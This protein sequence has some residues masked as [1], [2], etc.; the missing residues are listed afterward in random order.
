MGRHHAEEFVE[1][2]CRQWAVIKRQLLGVD[3]PKLAKE[4]IGALRSTL[5]QRRDLHAGSTS[6][7]RVEQ[8]WPEVFEGDAA[9]VNQVYR[10]MNPH[11]KTVLELHYI[12]RVPTYQKA[13]ALAMSV[14]TYYWHL[15]EVRGAVKGALLI[16]NIKTDGVAH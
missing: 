11:D 12:A 3:D 13:W 7:G 4:Y 1:K 9:I 2:A 6:E 5:G 14:P 15:R 16:G 8:H 10:A